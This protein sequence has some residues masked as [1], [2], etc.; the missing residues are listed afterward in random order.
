MMEHYPMVEK[1]MMIVMKR[2]RMVNM[3]YQ[4]KE[5]NPRKMDQ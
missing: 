1:K 5:T 3:K 4:K 2:K